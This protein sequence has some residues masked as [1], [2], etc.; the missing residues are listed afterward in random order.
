[1]CAFLNKVV[2]NRLDFCNYFLIALSIQRLV[3][4]GQG[5]FEGNCRLTSGWLLYPGGP[6]GVARASLR[7]SRQQHV[8]LRGAAGLYFAS[9]T[10]NHCRAVGLD[11]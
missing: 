9:Q 4:P 8:P 7:V 5:S 10:E 6:A 3:T 11:V 1:M 2:I